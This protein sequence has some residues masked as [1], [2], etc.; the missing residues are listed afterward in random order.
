M[1][2]QRLVKNKHCR[3]STYTLGSPK[4]S[5]K[6]HLLKNRLHQARALKK[7]L[8]WGMNYGKR[9]PPATLPLKRPSTARVHAWKRDGSPQTLRQARRLA[10]AWLTNTVSSQTHT[11]SLYDPALRRSQRSATHA[12]QWQT[13]AT[14]IQATRYTA[15]PGLWS[16]TEELVETLT[17]DASSPLPT[18]AWEALSSFHRPDIV[19]A[20]APHTATPQQDP[21]SDIFQ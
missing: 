9:W 7:H 2:H 4:M 15:D 5:P 16:L 12:D 14:M 6:H 18:H 1:I 20:L 10:T 19:S 17:R 21:A 13:A 3:A 11:V 8:P